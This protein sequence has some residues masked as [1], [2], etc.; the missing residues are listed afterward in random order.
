MSDQLY[1]FHGRLCRIDSNRSARQ[2][3]TE[4]HVVI[5]FLA[6]SDKGFEVIGCGNVARSD[7]KPTTQLV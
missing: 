3:N 7:L 5:E 2:H 1:E 6:L 4:T